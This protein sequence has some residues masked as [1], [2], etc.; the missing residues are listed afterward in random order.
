M[1]LK[2]NSFGHEGIRMISEG[3][4]VNSTLTELSLRCDLKKRN[5]RVKRNERERKRK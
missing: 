4:K 2:E 3:L 1:L 5:E